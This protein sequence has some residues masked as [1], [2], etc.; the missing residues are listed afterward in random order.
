MLCSAVEQNL[1]ATKRLLLLQLISEGR[2]DSVYSDPANGLYIF[3]SKLPSE[4]CL[5]PT[6]T[7]VVS[8]RQTHLTAAHPSLEGGEGPK[9]NYT[10]LQAFCFLQSNKS[11]C[12]GDGPDVTWAECP[13]SHGTTASSATGLTPRAQSSSALGKPEGFCDSAKL[14]IPTESG[15]PTSN[16]PDPRGCWVRRNGKWA[17]AHQLHGAPGSSHWEEQEQECAL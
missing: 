9:S 10:M 5:E 8:S 7:R 2:P 11:C 14:R 4:V 3:M 12:C 13:R 15:F 17:A 16:Y 6:V 1:R